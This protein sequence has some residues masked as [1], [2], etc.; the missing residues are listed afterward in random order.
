M[1]IPTGSDYEGVVKILNEKGF[2]ESEKGFRRV[3]GWMSFDQRQTMRSGRFEV[4]PGMSNRELIQ[5]LRNGKQS[6]VKLVM[7]YGRTPDDIAGR[8]APFIEADSAD[9]SQLFKD[10]NFLKD[11]GF[12]KE[13]AVSCLIPNTYEFYW[14]SSAE[15]FWKR[16]KKEH[17]K[18][19][20]DERKAKAK[21]INLSPEEVYTLA[22]I[23]EGETNYVPEKPK[24]AGVYVNRLKKGMLL[25][26]DPTLKFASGDWDARRLLDKHKEV[27]SPYNTYMYKGLPPGPISLASISSIDAVLNHANHDYF[28]FCAKVPENAGE[29]PREHAFAKTYS[30]H[31]R[32]AKKYWAYLKREGIR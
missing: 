11:E 4:K 29:K 8:V 31:L 19:W 10:V 20:T 21:S 22:S 25:Q 15:D 14:N 9:I 18:F 30:Q 24:V 13:T 16:M 6:P 23:V 12:K 27:D 26:A 1:K 32:N 28:Y 3:A 7:S 2:I 5:L 17:G